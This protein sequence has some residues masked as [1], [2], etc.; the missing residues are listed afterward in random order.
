MDPKKENGSLESV[1]TSVVRA[2]DILEYLNTC[3][4]PMTVAD[5]CRELNLNRITCTSLVKTLIAKKYLYKN[6]IGKI[7]LTGKVYVMGQ[8][9]KDGFPVLERFNTLALE[10][11]ERYGCLSHL[12]TFAGLNQ[13]ILLSH[14]PSISIYSD[15]L[16]LYVPLYCTGAGKV[17]LAY[18]PQPIRE[19]IVSAMELTPKT[20][21]TITDHQKLIET[22]GE[23]RAQGYGFDREEYRKGLFCVSAPVFNM[24]GSVHTAV[25]LTNLPVTSEAPIESFV[26][27]VLNL[28]RTL[29]YSSGYRNVNLEAL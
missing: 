21:N 16:H 19:A 23:I 14:V 26:P 22:L 27:S 11:T 18:Q 5:L 24:D 8:V 28:A 12:V 17:L 15:V 4:Q 25:S 29:S 7:C 20:E 10:Y 13:G 9:Y 2:L 3:G 6:E 1:N